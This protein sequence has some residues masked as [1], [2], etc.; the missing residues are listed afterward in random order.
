MSVVLVAST[1]TSRLTLATG[2]DSV[3]APSGSGLFPYSLPGCGVGNLSQTATDSCSLQ[4]NSDQAL[5][6][7]QPLQQYFEVRLTVLQHQAWPMLS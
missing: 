1:G 5:N 3:H 7:Q 6:S 4:L 2:H